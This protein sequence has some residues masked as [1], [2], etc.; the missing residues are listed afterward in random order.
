MTDDTVFDITVVDGGPTGLFGLFCAGMREMSTKVIDSLKELGGQLITLYPEKFIYDMPGFP[1]V[2]A[3]DL[4]REM[5]EQGLQ[6]G[7]VPVLGSRVETLTRQDDGVWLL[8]LQNG[9]RHAS[10]TIV[11]TAGA[12]G[13]EPR[14]LPLD[15]AA[16]WEGKGIHY[17]VREL[18][19][20]RGRKVLIV[21]G[22]DSAVDCAIHLTP[23]AEKVTLIHRRDRFRAHEGS[24]REMMGLPVDVKLFWEVG[25][26]RGD[27]LIREVTLFEN[28][29][30]EI[31]CLEVDD[32]LLWLGFH[33]DLGPI[34]TWGLEMQGQQNCVNSRMETNLPGVYAAGDVATYDGKLK[35]IATGVGEAT[36]AVNYAKTYIDPK[37]KAFPGH[38]SEMDQPP[39]QPA[40][41]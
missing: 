13:F 11:I 19:R 21:G 10:R 31:C 9:D 29:T 22:G 18:E 35:L 14:R 27:G 15:D 30:K 25:E 4:V 24:V 7:A 33:A 20:Y 36:I 38:S 34:K 40:A 39:G 32:L 23:L 2:L 1:K 26:I 28:R 3:K 16:S 41:A 37:A 17:F 6:Y 12:G 5:V 8:A